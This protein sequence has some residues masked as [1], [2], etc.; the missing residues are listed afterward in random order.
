[1]HDALSPQSPFSGLG[2]R[3]SVGWAREPFFGGFSARVASWRLP[4]AIT[5]SSTSYL[6][7]RRE[8]KIGKIERTSFCT[9]LHCLSLC[10][11]PRS[12]VESYAQ[13]RLVARRH[14]LLKQSTCVRLVAAMVA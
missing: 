7:N 9:P 10:L 2:L 8:G 3:F 1:M 6:L 11:Q 14:R 13:N 12:I 4:E 5:T